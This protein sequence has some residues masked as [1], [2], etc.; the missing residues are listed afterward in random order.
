MRLGKLTLS[1]F[2]RFAGRT[3][4]IDFGA[5]GPGVIAICGP[6]GAGKTTLME[7]T[8]P[9]ILYGEFPSRAPKM[10]IQHW[11]GPSGGSISLTFTL[12]G[13][14]YEAEVMV[15][16][17][18][19]KTA[20]LRKN[21]K[22]LTSGK[23]RDYGDA[24]EKLFGPK[25]AFYASV[26]GTQGGAG[27]LAGL[28]VADRRKVFQYYLGHERINAC[29]QI[30]KARLDSLP[31]AELTSTE[32]KVRETEA[33]LVRVRG[34]RKTAEMES[35]SANK[36]ERLLQEELDKMVAH[37]ALAGMLAEYEEAL[38]AI[39]D[40]EEEGIPAKGDALPEEAV[41][42]LQ[43]QDLPEMEKDLR[44]WERAKLGLPALRSELSRAEETR[45][46]LERAAKVM[47]SVPCGQYEGDDFRTCQFL[48][49][50]Q[51]ASVALPEARGKEKAARKALKDEEAKVS[52]GEG[53][54]EQ[55][56]LIRARIEKAVRYRTWTGLRE[57]AI[58]LRKALPSVIPEGI[59]SAEDIALKRKE[60]E[61]SAKD[62]KEALRELSSIE[63]RVAALERN[64]EEL[65]MKEVELKAKCED[66]QALFLLS[67]ALTPR[68]GIPAME[69]A[70]AGPGVT[71]IANSLLRAAYGSR[72]SL[73]I[74][75]VREKGDG[76]L[77]EDFS[78]RVYDDLYGVENTIEGVSK[79]ESVLI[80]E[81]LRAAQALYRTDRTG[82]PCETLWR[83][84][85]VGD[86]D[87]ERSAKYVSILHKA[88]EIGG[89]YQVLYVSHDERA[90]ETADH[91]IR[92]AEDGSV[93]VA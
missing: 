76:G 26:F 59:P 6:N 92:I 27:S 8:G 22:P 5:I 51:E 89:F 48:K 14:R 29:Y 39:G 15:G 44:L 43:S 19:T 71:A 49:D 75:T 17:G 64:L 91:V 13:D 62:A 35:Q 81:C 37:A 82:V 56:D 2:T 84:E 58:R 86:L 3:V 34:E 28:E 20:T 47:E 46:R 21:G 42:R 18:G 45:A 1:G 25:E 61:V 33:T 70:A 9:G 85:T 50:A 72:F 40:F 55:V 38:D 87:A 93:E 31:V 52:S 11:A 83:D 68:G 32:T 63:E 41:K 78:I 16:K 7:S 69:I 66:S 23:V 4:E 74:E 54:S 79:G 30:V 88:R 77:T 12:G 60:R 73:S 10:G 57:R 80:D 24:I 53:I 36:A 67:R 65:R 90:I